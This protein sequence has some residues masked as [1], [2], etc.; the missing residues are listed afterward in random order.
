M[1]VD[2]RNGN[3]AMDY[4]SHERTYAG[5]IAATKWGTAIVIAILVLMAIFLL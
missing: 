5:F 2:T 3:P 4:R 1:T